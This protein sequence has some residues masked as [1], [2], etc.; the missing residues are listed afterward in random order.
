MTVI[1]DRDA[2]HEA[3]LDLGYA[4]GKSLGVIALVKRFGPRLRL[5]LKPWVQ[6]RERRRSY[7]L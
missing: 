6:E 2:L 3:V 4:I 7:G 1:E 5:R